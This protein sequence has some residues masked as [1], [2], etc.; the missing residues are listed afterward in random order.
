[1]MT[2]VLKSKNAHNYKETCRGS[3]KNYPIVGVNILALKTTFLNSE[4]LQKYGGANND[5]LSL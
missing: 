2:R 3:K 5:S 1:M 4:L